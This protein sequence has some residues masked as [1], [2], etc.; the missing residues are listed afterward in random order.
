MLD[1]LGEALEIVYSFLIVYQFITS[2]MDGIDG[3]SM[4]CFFSEVGFV[5]DLAGDIEGFL[6]EERRRRT[7]KTIRRFLV[8]HRKQYN[9][10]FQK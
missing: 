9:R 10:R 8:F 2:I 5:G 1:E 4:S 6:F 3:L 7:M